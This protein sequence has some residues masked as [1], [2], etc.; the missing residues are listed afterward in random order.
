MHFGI[1]GCKLD[2]SVNFLCFYSTV[3]KRL[4]YII[5]NTVHLWTFMKRWYS[6][7][8]RKPGLWLLR[9]GRFGKLPQMPCY[10]HTTMKL[11]SVIVPL[12]PSLSTCFFSSLTSCPGRLVGP[13]SLIG[14][15]TTDVVLN[16]ETI[17]SLSRPP[18]LISQHSCSLAF[19]IFKFQP[20]ETRPK[21]PINFSTIYCGFYNQVF[22]TCTP[23]KCRFLIFGRLTDRFH[24]FTLVKPLILIIFSIFRLL[25]RF[26]RI[27]IAHLRLAFNWALQSALSEDVRYISMD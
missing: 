2:V 20:L 14:P 13:L 22:P 10:C 17:I 5:Q 16:L 11:L 26:Y 21:L 3:F 1:H 25:C 12:S 6:V 15:Q 23:K 18:R 8:P 24:L 4:Q 7:G 9:F 19:S 27:Y